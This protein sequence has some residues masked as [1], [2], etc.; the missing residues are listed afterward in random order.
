[1][2]KLLNLLTCALLA[3][4]AAACDNNPVEVSFAQPFPAGRAKATG[5]APQDQG[6]YVALDDTARTLLVSSRR[7]IA[8]RAEM[9]TLSGAQL[10]SLGLPRQAG[11]HQARTG[12][13]YQVAPLAAGTFQ[14]HWQS[15]DTLVEVVPGQPTQ[16]RRYRGWYY[17]STQTAANTW[18]VER[19][20]FVGGQL[21]WQEFCR[22]SLR[23][24]A[25]APS[26]VSLTRRESRL[27]FT[28]NPTPGPATRQVS[29]Y[30]GLWLAKAEYQG[31]KH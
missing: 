25:L 22:D 27:L 14:L 5:F 23:I 28:L 13:V 17:L 6:R 19:L 16:L 9:L 26:S 30:Q 21:H 11:R 3:G 31:C 1:M 20:A 12:Q 8:Q 7:L 4:V 2:K 24:R 10:D 29:R 18:T 15:P